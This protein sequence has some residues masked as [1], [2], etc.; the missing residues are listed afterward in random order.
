MILEAKTLVRSVCRA[1]GLIP[2]LH[3]VR[4]LWHSSEYEDK[5]AA[6]LLSSV[7]PDDCVWDV[8]ANVGFYTEQFSKRARCVVAFEPL[9]ENILH[10]TSRG[11]PN[12][13]CRQV[14]LGNTRAQML[15]SRRAQFSSIVARPSGPS[16]ATYETVS[17]TPG[18]ALV[19]LP[20]PNVVKIDVEGYEPEVING[21]PHV[22]SQVRA[23]FIE[24][25]FSI[26]ESR[27]MLQQPVAI[28]KELKRLG[29]TTVKWVDASHIK[30]LRTK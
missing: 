5:F 24:V 21:M 15:I 7:R 28:V 27:G 17:V 9:A 23:A 14:A 20:M 3:R 10:I 26:L 30:A 25:H 6:A 19:G 16:D 18:D 2:A 22:L 1:L 13:D 29:F 8:G 11:L 12:V 4:S